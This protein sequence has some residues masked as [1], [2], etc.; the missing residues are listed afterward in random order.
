MRQPAFGGAAWRLLA[1]LL[2]TLAATTGRPSPAEALDLRQLTETVD[3]AVA[4]GREPTGELLAGF[5]LGPLDL[6]VRHKEFV[7]GM[8]RPHLYVKPARNPL[9]RS[10][11]IEAESRITLGDKAA[12]PLGL[13]FGLD[14][15]NE[16]NHSLRLA[17]HQGLQLPRLRLEHRLALTDSY[18]A[19]GS[20]TRS[21][22]GRLGL[23]LDLFGGR[24]EGV[25]EYG[26]TVAR[27]A[28]VTGLRTSSQWSFDAGQTAIVGLA[29]RPLEE[30][31]EARVG[32]RQP[33]GAFTLTSDA[34]AD[35]AGGYAL[36]IQVS[37]PF[38]RTVQRQPWT[39]SG[40]AASLRAARPQPATAGSGAYS[41]FDEAG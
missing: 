39:L 38:G 36:G 7:A 3:L 14:E 4:A 33:L 32:F 30:L 29:H 26:Y 27:D 31:S 16:G 19:E 37:L 5:A 21:G 10:S 20:R 1:A 17:V 41:L 40:L 24:H 18:A 15:W 22:T 13:S 8:G 34:A 23:G 25:A 28:R 9:A 2:L 6:N 35:S 12:L 11:L